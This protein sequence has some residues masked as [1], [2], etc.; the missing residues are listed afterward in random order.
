[1]TTIVSPWSGKPN[2]KAIVNYAP[3]II[4]DGHPIAGAADNY[5][6]LD[7]GLLFNAAGT[8]GRETGF[9]QDDYD[10]H[11][12]SVEA[13][14]VHFE[15]GT[16]IG[17]YVNIM[18]FIREHL[19]LAVNGRV[20]DIGCGKGM[21]L[22][23]FQRQFPEWQLAAIEPSK[24][25]T[26]FFAKVMPKLAVFEG[27]FEASPFASERFDF[28]MANGV[29]EHVPA[30]HEFLTRFAGC[31]ADGGFGFIGVPNL[32]TNPADLL[33]F[34]HLSKLTPNVTRD[35]FRSVGLRV[36]AEAVPGTRVP[37][38]FLVERDARV[39]AEPQAV[40][41]DEEVKIAEHARDFVTKSFA[42]CEAAI[43]A[44]RAD[45][46]KLAVYGGGA[47]ALCANDHTSMKLTDVEC[48][49]DDSP[50]LWGQKRLGVPVRPAEELRT[51]NIGHLVISANSCYYK[52]IK[53]RIRELT[54]DN[55][56][57]VYFAEGHG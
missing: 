50:L 36:R 16:A 4:S 24:N 46:K 43:R 51:A 7:T 3:S 54:G 53:T 18:T 22:N 57:K 55:G 40:N 13:E 30:P 49:F 23:R 29:L 1:M 38:W 19:S 20:L 37:M 48:I 52:A 28:V 56:P 10:L 34:D 25:A 17:L 12:D 45:G 2:V 9:Y 6:C 44:S 21:L 33:T 26:R 5:V 41:I 47:I 11:S 39:L 8:R 42:S 27:P 32:V 15:T 14:F 35:L 31:I